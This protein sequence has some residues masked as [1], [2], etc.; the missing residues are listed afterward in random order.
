MGRFSGMV[1]RVARLVALPRTPKG[2]QAFFDA[3]AAIVVFAGNNDFP[4]SV[5]VDHEITHATLLRNTSLGLLEQIAAFARWLGRESLPP[6]ADALEAEADDLLRVVRRI[7]EPVHEAVAWFGTELQSRGYE[8]F[9]APRMYRR[10]VARLAKTIALLRGNPDSTDVEPHM[11]VAE[12]IGVYALSPPALREL[13]TGALAGP[14]RPH[15]TLARRLA[16]RSENPI[17]RFRRLCAAIRDEPFEEALAWSDSVFAAAKESEPSETGGDSV[18]RRIAN[19]PVVHRVEL[20]PHADQI[21]TEG[22]PWFTRVP[23]ELG[24][25]SYRSNVQRLLKHPDLLASAQFPFAADDARWQWKWFRAIT[26]LAWDLDRY[27][28][29]CVLP[30]T[31]RSARPVE[32][33]EDAECPPAF[34]SAREVV[35]SLGR[36]DTYPFGWSK[37]RRDGRVTLAVQHGG[38]GGWSVWVTADGTARTYLERQMQAGAAIVVNGAAYDYDV[39]DVS[40]GPLIAD[41]PH[42][43]MRLTDFRSFW[44]EQAVFGQGGLGG[45]PVI[46]WKPLPF[47]DDPS[48]YYGFLVLRGADE[49]WPVVLIPSIVGQYERVVSIA[50]TNPSSF[51]I[52]LLQVEGN[53]YFWLNT[54]TEM[55]R[56]AARMFEMQCR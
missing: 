52:R 23:G 43:V 27:A 28:Q 35:V 7:S 24:S 19:I 32:V 37:P 53:A 10:D 14:E 26:S 49:S 31:R 55:T 25:R 11:A 4:P 33:I 54:M 16:A 18:R 50:D 45:S 39:G 15:R 6:E 5:L 42:V 29:T 40:G 30:P 44:F 56:D 38:G 22:I 47:V 3:D 36:S 51:G 2:E 48:A 34:A 12:A 20:Q 21:V 9:V 17:D 13:F 8:N 41:I 46:H 1:E